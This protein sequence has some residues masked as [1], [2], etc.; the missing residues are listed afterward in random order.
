MD[1]CHMCRRSTGA[2]DG[3]RRGAYDTFVADEQGEEILGVGCVC[4]EIAVSL[5]P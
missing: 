1:H 5:H 3:Y 2:T 4:L